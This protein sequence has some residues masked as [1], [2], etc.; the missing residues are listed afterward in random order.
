MTLMC[1]K[2]AYDWNTVLT[3]RWKARVRVMSVP[4]IR[5]WPP[6]GSSRP[7]TIRRVVVFPHPEGPSRAKKDPS[8]MVRSRGCTAVNSPKLLVSPTSRRSPASC[9]AISW[10]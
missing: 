6:V 1:G 2:S 4:P 10:Q 9:S 8:G 5:I 7:A 3:L